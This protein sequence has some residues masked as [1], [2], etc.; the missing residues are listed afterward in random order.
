MKKLFLLSL[1]TLSACVPQAPML[2]GQQR[3]IT[4]T[5]TGSAVSVPNLFNFSVVLEERGTS[6]SELNRVVTEKTNQVIQQLQDLKVDAKNIQSLQVQFNPWIEYNGQSQEQKG[7]ILS[8]RIE[9]SLDDLG[10]YDKVI[11]S[12]LQL[13]INRLE[14]F[15]YADSEAHEH[16]QMAVSQALLDAKGKASQ[17]ASVLQLKLGRAIAVSELSQGQALRAEK[18]MV[19]RASADT[20]SLPGE[21]STKAQVSVVFEL[22]D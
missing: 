8:R 2:Q 5:G 10:Q 22:V 21:M 18:N 16:Y 9:I 3:Q 19:F 12:V 6:A 15:S 17:M 20:S 13:K 1:L 14:G 4:V 11:D 7:F